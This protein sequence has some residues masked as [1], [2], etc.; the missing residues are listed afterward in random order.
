VLLHEY[1]HF[2]HN[3]STASGFSAFQCFQHLLA[4]FSNALRE[5]GTCD[6]A[7]LSNEQRIIAREALDA[8]AS[9][10]GTR[11]L[12]RHASPV[13]ELSVLV[14][15]CV[16]A[17]VGGVTVEQADV[18]WVI[19]R[20]DG[21]REEF[22][23]PIGAS[24]IEEGIAFTLE[25]SARLGRVTF[26]RS[27]DHP[28]PLYPYEAFRILV[29][30]CAPEISALSA[31][32]RGLLALCTNRPGASLL[33]ALD[34][35]RRL[36]TSG[37]DDAA[38]CRAIRGALDGMIRAITERICSHELGE[39]S[40]MHFER[41]IVTDGHASVLDEFR[42]LLTQRASDPWFDVAWCHDDGTVDLK[43]L[44]ALFLN[45]V[46]CDAIQEGWGPKD[47]VGRDVLLTFKSGG[48]ERADGSVAPTA[49]NSGLRAVQAQ[50]DFLLAHLSP[51]HG[52]VA[53]QQPNWRPCP[54]FTSCSLDMRRND[55]EACRETPWVRLTKKGETCWYGVAVAATLGTVRES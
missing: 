39:L 22:A 9:L 21:G 51:S 33:H 28:P 46:P 5:D 53:A 15:R 19:V 47:D 24:L 42:R 11:T 50:F 36:R 52:I 48:V 23:A 16:P 6:P 29:Q 43:S 2:L 12:P 55:P 1:T 27:G 25:E 4:V 34:A 37:V 41:G 20:R 30:H 18:E 8:L 38:A 26:D 7:Q 10:E 17:Q 32:R 3:L 49:A 14:A 44:S 54:F 13:T 31:I 35:Y 40:R 45:T